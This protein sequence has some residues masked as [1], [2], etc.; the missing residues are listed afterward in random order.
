MCNKK[1]PDICTVTFNPI[2]ITLLMLNLL[3]SVVTA[4]W[5]PA[6]LLQQRIKKKLTF[7]LQNFQ[8]KIFTVDLKTS[9]S[10]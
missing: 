7:C 3:V 6:Y 2:M 1:S 10:K 8:I 9:N 5:P 4:W